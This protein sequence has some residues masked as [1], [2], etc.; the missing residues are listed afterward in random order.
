MQVTNEETIV[1]VDSEAI[2]Y[3]VLPLLDDLSHPEQR[4]L[5]LNLVKYVLLGQSKD[6]PPQES[7]DDYRRNCI[8]FAKMV[9]G[10]PAQ[11]VESIREEM[12]QA[13]AEGHVPCGHCKV[14]T[15]VGVPERGEN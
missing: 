10:L 8:A 4:L 2:Y 7:I 6:Y 12:E 5:M 9:L 15:A 13:R 3:S 14:C 1:A 11:F